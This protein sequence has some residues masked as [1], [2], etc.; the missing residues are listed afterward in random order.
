MARRGSATALRMPSRTA[1]QNSSD[2]PLAWMIVG[3]Q[4]RR[5]VKVATGMCL[6]VELIVLVVSRRPRRARL[7]HRPPF[8][9]EGR[10]LRTCRTAVAVI[11]VVQRIVV[12]V[13]D[14]H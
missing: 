3:Q 7:G 9:H 1:A 5:N 11:L 10:P 14:D 8:A 12:L 2:L 4:I 6:H 13:T